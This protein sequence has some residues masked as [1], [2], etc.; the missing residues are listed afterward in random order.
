MWVCSRS[1]AVGLVLIS[2]CADVVQPPTVTNAP[3]SLV[4]GDD[5]RLEAFE[6]PVESGATFALVPVS[7]LKA[8]GAA[9]EFT[10]LTLRTKRN[11]CPN[12]L[13]RE[14]VSAA[15][16]SGVLVAPHLLL[17]AGHCYPYGGQCETFSY[18]ADYVQPAD[19]GRLVETSIENVYGCRDLARIARSPVA[20]TSYLLDYAAVV[21][22]RTPERPPMQIFGGDTLVGEAVVV[23]GATSGLPLKS[24]AG[25]VV[26][27][28][29]DSNYFIVDADTFAGS[30]GGPVVDQHGKLRGLLVGGAPGDYEETDAGCNATHSLPQES[31]RDNGQYVLKI[32]ALL[33]DLCAGGSFGEDLCQTSPVCGDEACEAAEIDRC[34]ECKAVRCNGANCIP[35]RSEFDGASVVST[36]PTASV[37]VSGDQDS[38]AGCSLVMGERRTNLTFLPLLLF[39]PI[40]RKDRS[41]GRSR[42]R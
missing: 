11:L 27:A 20:G 38:G 4:F 39:C 31:A 26:R 19:G 13:F 25:V 5:D 14:Q 10:S 21:L 41:S 34:S 18:V 36:F 12:Q 3:S 40:L 2:A 17:T 37:G 30:S 1:A 29:S 23:L 22:D 16:C 35:E 8:T 42:R 9:V 24:S 6:G 15:S 28:D 33:L 7:N 32:S